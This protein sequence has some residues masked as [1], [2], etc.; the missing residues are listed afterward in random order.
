MKKLLMI[1]MALA[2]GMAAFGE[3][4]A[5]ARATGASMRLDTRAGVRIAAKG[6]SETIAYSPRWARDGEGAAA[7][8][9]SVTADGATLKTASDEGEVAWSPTTT[10]AHTL[11]HTAG[12]VA[13]TA[14]FTVLGDDVQFHGGV[15]P[16]IE[17][18]YEIVTN[19]MTFVVTNYNY[20]VVWPADKVHLIDS[21]LTV[22]GYMTLMIEPGAVVKFMTG[23]SLS[24]ES[25]AYCTANGVIF[26]HVNDDTVGGDTLM[27]GDATKP[28]MDGYKLT[29]N[30]YEDDATEERYTAPQTLTSSISG[31]L[32]LKGYKV[33]LANS[34]ITVN[35]GATLTLL[36]GAI[37]K[38]AS[39]CSMT[40]NGTLDAQGTR[41][42]PIVFTSAKDDDWGGD[43]NGDGP[44][45][46]NPGEW[47][48]IRV[49]GGRAEMSNVQVL[50]S[51]RNLDVGAIN[52]TSSGGTVVFNDG[53]IAGCRYDAVGV[54]NGNVYMTNSVIRDAAQAFRHWT[55]DPIVNCVIYD[56]GKLTQGGGQHFVNCV[57]SKISETWE[58]FGFPQNGTTYRNCC[59]WN[60]GG[61]VLTG[62]GTQDA[63][64]VCGKDGNIWGNPRFLDPD[65]GDFRIA[66]DSPCVDAG[67]TDTAPAKD[68]YGQPR[69][70]AA[71][72]IGIC[73][74]LPRYAASD[75]DL[76]A[77]DVSAGTTVTVGEDITVAWTVENLGS[78]AVH[79]AWRDKVELVSSRGER[80]LLGE[81]MT[82]TGLA[83]GG[84]Q[85]CRGSWKVP[86]VAEGEYTVAVTVNYARDVFE[87][88]LTANN[89]AQSSA[90]QVEVPVSDISESS[91]CVIPASGES[92]LH[93]VF[94][95]ES[96]NRMITIRTTEGVTAIF[97]THGV[98]TEFA[99]V[100]VVSASGGVISFRVPDETNDVYVRLVNAGAQDVDCAVA[101]SVAK[102]QIVNVSPQTV[103]YD[104]KVTVRIEGAGL[105]RVNQLS[106][107]AA[108]GSLVNCDN[109]RISSSG[110]IVATAD[111][112]KL[113]Q[114]AQ[115]R[116]VLTDFDG[117]V[118]E[119]LQLVTVTEKPAKPEIW[120]RMDVPQTVRA[121]R[122]YVCT[123]E[124]GNRGNAD[125]IAPILE[126]SL[127][128][129]GSLSRIDE[130]VSMKKL[131]LVG[132]GGSGD[133]GILLPGEQ[134]KVSFAY[135]AGSSADSVSLRIGESAE[136]SAAAARVGA[137]GMEATD[138]AL[139]KELVADVAAGR[140]SAVF[141]RVTDADGEPVCGVALRFEG[142]DVSVDALTD[143]LGW[144]VARG[145]DDGEY[146]VF[147]NGQTK[148]SPSRIVIEEG[149]D[150]RLDVVVPAPNLTV[151][152]SDDCD[153]VYAVAWD[154]V[155]ADEL[156]AN[157]VRNGEWVFYGLPIGRYRIVACKGDSFA[158]AQVSIGT[159][160]APEVLC[161]IPQRHGKISGRVA[162]ALPSDCFIESGRPVVWIQGEA[163]SYLVETDASGTYILDD[164]PSGIYAIELLMPDSDRVGQGEVV[165]VEGSA[166]TTHDI[167]RPGALEAESSSLKSA[168]KKTM[169][170]SGKPSG[171]DFNSWL[172][173]GWQVY[174]ENQV[175][176]PASP[177]NC[178]H[179]LSKYWRDRN[180]REEFSRDLD[181]FVRI[182][183]DAS[184]L[185][186]WGAYAQG[187]VLAGKQVTKKAKAAVNGMKMV[188]ELSQEVYDLAKSLSGD[189]ASLGE[190]VESFQNDIAEGATGIKQ[191]LFAII[192]LAA[193][194][195]D[196]AQL[197][198]QQERLM[199]HL[200][201]I[202]RGCKRLRLTKRIS[203]H[204]ELLEKCS[205]LFAAIDYA[206]DLKEAWEHGE[207]IADVQERINTAK[208][209]MAEMG[210]QVKLAV[211]W[212]LRKAEDFNAYH[213]CVGDEEEDVDTSPVQTIRASS[214]KSVD[215][216]EMV[217]PMGKGDL[218]T[219]RFVKPGEWMTYTV[220]FENKADATAAAQEVTVTNPLSE[221][222]D[223]STFEMG[224]VAF[225]NQI[226][227]GLVGKKNGTSE[228]TMNGTNY[229]VRTE[230]KL[231]VKT[232]VADWYMRIVDPT[233][234]TGWPEDVFAGFLP[235]NDE[236]FR[237]EGHLTYRIKVR[238]D[239]PSGVRIDNSATIIFDYNDPIET[240]PAWWNTVSTMTEEATGQYVK[241]DLV[242][243]LGIEIPTNVNYAVGDKVTVKVEG[244][245]KGL[246]VVTTQQKET[247]GK[248][249]VTNVI[250]TIEGVP[251]EAIDF[252]TRPMYARVTVTYKDKAMGEK[253]KVELLQP[254][255]L[256]I[257]TP[258]PSV[259]TAGVL[260]G[261]YGPAD[262]AALWP[263]V[264]DAKINPKDWSF[265]GWPAGIKYNNKATAANWSY[266]DGKATV[267][268]NA[269]P[270]TV[271]GQPTKAGE[272]PI[273]ATWKHKLDD[274]KTT[275]SE[276]FSAVLTVWGDD[277]ASD[278]RYEDQAYVA[279]AT[280]TLD[281]DFKSFSGLPTGIKY[282]T[283]PVT[284]KNKDGS[285]TTNVVAYS[286]YGTPT[287]AGVYAVTATK[288][289]PADPAGKKTVKETFLW[290]VAPA[291]APVF[292]L[293]T[294]TA[295]VEE[296]KA[297]IVQGAN[298]AFAI[299]A[300][301]GAKVTATG[302]PSGL[303]LVQDKATKA[304]TVAGVASK[305][306]EYFVTFK[307]VLN[308]VTTVTTTAFTV[309]ANP[310][311]GV[312]R[313]SAITE[314][315]AD[316][317]RLA[318]FE[319]TV[320]VNGKVS[321]SYNEGKTKYS[322]SAKSYDYD[323]QSAG[324]KVASLTFKASS[325]DKKAGL[326][327]R[328]AELRL[329]GHDGLFREVQ[330]FVDGA[331]AG[332][333][334][335]TVKT[336]DE[337]VTLPS[338][339]TYVFTNGVGSSLA[340][341]SVAWDAKKATA[342]YIGKLFDGTAI[343]MS[344]PVC[345]WACEGD[346]A[347]YVFAP[348]QVIAKDKTVY[349]LGDGFIDW[350]EGSER[351]DSLAAAA[352]C[353]K[354]DKKLA[355][356]V[357][358]E[359]ALTVVGDG[360]EPETF[361]FAV[362][363]DN[364]QKPSAVEIYDAEPQEG[365][366]PLAKVT[367]K[368]GKATGGITITLTSKKGD[369]AKYVIDL[370]WQDDC[371]LAGQVI[372]TWNGIVD[373][374]PANLTACGTA[375][376]K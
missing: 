356:V 313:G 53:L 45:V 58:A 278:F 40:V 192:D 224:E 107:R 267:K 215:P 38:F 247:T 352:V 123:I 25:G 255:A 270:Y 332:T 279:T 80:I 237:G 325:D 56:C 363:F 262:I 90:V 113:K 118:L 176:Y 369:K 235:P 91:G 303:K 366:K 277:G 181:R 164:V 81:K 197:Y 74:V 297:Q 206:S 93:F 166:T 252:E 125:A 179:N 46:I 265:K 307:T 114:G 131:F 142:G 141:G 27:D 143:N 311:A 156:M 8:S 282:T 18:V 353:D 248:K 62:E 30:I 334:Y 301:E 208:G 341:L 293:D 88:T 264:A 364:K 349:L 358:E 275:V 110:L 94:G 33:Y 191:T 203:H 306:G 21:P 343:K 216:N 154:S 354:G 355:E 330:V 112:A 245:A 138:Y 26:T 108:D 71:A 158:D 35:S 75:V 374:K 209:M 302:L 328:R 260:N 95:A 251:T 19:D 285:V 63:M 336:L 6:A 242:D 205:K 335:G 185:E 204:L 344:V 375:E 316:D 305:P 168:L 60:E 361:L 266:K 340:T 135:V 257:T 128:G 234:E 376:V 9:C 92:V 120:A 106:Y 333:G 348:F 146:V 37:I 10:G 36:P 189:L 246:K 83:A 127:S 294:G 271:Y 61:S 202:Q 84:R 244:L 82:Q 337:G 298:Q 132:A 145:L 139:A 4:A 15:L 308:G 359:G 232:G 109:W 130:G 319:V 182:R 150:I 281:A 161:L 357:P 284:T 213:C 170:G 57:F 372:R 172:D 263:E 240:D 331:L 238:E 147:L 207:K 178:R 226:D 371:Y 236:T 167:V 259:L 261:V 180:V 77:S 24:V 160:G 351:Q 76:R 105:D 99:N 233:T 193:T 102:M 133:A 3:S 55:R 217:G 229:A 129:S 288:V 326:P 345:R 173:Y 155:G 350:I 153:G 148:A 159:E 222:L 254:I 137:R 2:A 201:Q 188:I 103:P 315:T 250:Y 79:D 101:F 66:A 186:L 317:V 72:D 219:E 140:G 272:Y 22:P 196:L 327:D 136:L 34:S 70:G 69:V 323:F 258:D 52:V 230:L 17:E 13:Y 29:G 59:F 256:S 338:L 211:E 268:T 269:E 144:Y 299:T 169:L 68:Y 310:F 14:Q 43:T 225:N 7:T 47:D 124:Y 86:V 115:Y 122:S 96:D 296:L 177:Y 12:S 174:R 50:Y 312:Y 87:G 194:G 253:G 286:L 212:F 78:A 342:A 73:E 241:L 119:S 249:A 51:S 171:V 32:R 54:E 42:A 339:Q 287:K 347:D 104:G 89:V 239:A 283:K 175:D 365:E 31:T 151:I 121:G 149:H 221:W 291:D 67:D 28:V 228:V 65:N 44:S 200:D 98:P 218:E 280:K 117:E 329:R 273:T 85:V 184:Q 314:R 100:G 370:V 163:N 367:T 1:V 368:L 346:A 309:Q 41:A 20:N 23:T 231:D 227:L 187:A 165:R 116:F 64:K 362:V 183:S 360:L 190:D 321:I 16:P 289:D 274:S 126:V 322:A 220:Y 198:V 318:M 210:S 111:G 49:S 11:T 157:L 295:P 223:W 243:E 5:F 195:K 48:C 162:G 199:H 373:G 39:G 320:G 292:A 152:T 97:G 324:G 290:K 134:R 276:T 304:Y 300:S 214:V